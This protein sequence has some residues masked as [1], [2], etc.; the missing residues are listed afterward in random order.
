MLI[1]TGDFCGNC[2]KEQRTVPALKSLSCDFC[3]VSQTPAVGS[4]EAIRD[5]GVT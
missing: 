3:S 1:K 2:S 5:T 4:T